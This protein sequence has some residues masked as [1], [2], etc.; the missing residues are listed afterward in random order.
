M[1]RDRATVRRRAATSPLRSSAASASPRFGAAR[2]RPPWWRS[3][4]SARGRWPRSPPAYELARAARRAR[5][6]E[7]AAATTRRQAGGMRRAAACT[8]L[9]AW[10]PRMPLSRAGIPLVARRRRAPG[11][12]P[13]C[14]WR[15]RRSPAYAGTDGAVDGDCESPSPTRSLAAGALAHAPSLVLVRDGRAGG[16]RRPRLQDRR[17][18]RGGDRC[19]GWPAPMTQRPLSAATLRPPTALDPS[20][21]PLARSPAPSTI[22]S[23]AFPVRLLPLGAGPRTPSPTSPASASTSSIS[24]RRTRAASR[25][26]SS[27]SCR[28]RTAASSSR[29]GRSTGGSRSTTRD[30]VFEAV[31]ARASPADVEPIFTDL[32]DARPVSLPS[33][34]WRTTRT[35]TLY[36][37]MTSWFEGV[38]YRDYDVTRGRLAPARRA[39][40]RRERPVRPCAGVA[41]STPIMSQ[42]GQRGR[43]AVTR[44]PAPPRSSACLGGARCEA[45]ADFGVPTSKVAWHASGRRIAF[46]VPRRRRAADDAEQGIFVLDRDAP[47]LTRLPTSEGASRL[48]FPDFVGDDAVVFLVPGGGPERS[49]VLRVVPLEP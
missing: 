8:L 33:A 27:T 25:P 39:C 36:R 1:R 3:A 42:D 48:A 4:R 46:A 23:S 41:L 13:R 17:G 2:D 16:R 10:T 20:E 40:A 44:R 38:V 12:P 5:F 14:S 28:P 37:V 31:R 15:T 19:D 34:S 47:G 45:L 11:R 21:A 35:R 24:A 9:Y 26:A 6:R 49:S 29:P 18:L 43:R 7:N 30:E 32:T 22:P